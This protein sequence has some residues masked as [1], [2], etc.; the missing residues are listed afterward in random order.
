MF[1]LGEEPL[2]IPPSE[3]FT[4]KCNFDPFYGLTKYC[5]WKYPHPPQLWECYLSAMLSFRLCF[6]KSTSADPL[7]SGPRTVVVTHLGVLWEL[8]RQLR[9]WPGPVLMCSGPQSHPRHKSTH[10]FF[11]CSAGVPTTKPSAEL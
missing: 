4:R 10:C 3:L 11:E 6:Q 7:K 5:G 8:W 9:F 2:S 1:L